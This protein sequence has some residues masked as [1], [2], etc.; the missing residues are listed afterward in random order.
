MGVSHS[1]INN[2]ANTALFLPHNKSNK[3]GPDHMTLTTNKDGYKWQNEARKEL[4]ECSAEAIKKGLKKPSKKGLE[5]T[6][7]SD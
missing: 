3:M 2:Y 6:K 4:D 1:S 7:K 5:K